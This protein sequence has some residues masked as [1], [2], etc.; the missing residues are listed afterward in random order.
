MPVTGWGEDAETPALPVT[1]MLMARRE[2][3]A[4]RLEI[5]QARSAA[6]DARAAREA[7][8]SAPD[9]D[10]Y[11][12]NFLARGYAPGMISQ[13]SMQLADV[14]AEL[15]GEEDKLEKAA[16]RAE[17][18]RQMHERGQIGG[19][20][21]LARMADTDEGDEGRVRVLQRR[22]ESLRRQIGEATEL[23]AP[24]RAP[25]DPLEA[26]SRNAHAIFREL[27]RAK[28]AEAQA[29]RLASPPFSSVSRAGLSAADAAECTGADCPVCAEGRRMDAAR[30]SE[31]DTDP[32]APGEGY[33][34]V[35]R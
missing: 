18:T 16:R 31:G 1:S 10:Q 25:E 3:Q 12:A 26:P 14:M 13:L 30:N 33:A 19:F 35:Y 6:D 22:A 2:H 11:A 34:E 27:T 28:M 17:R 29:G 15:A 24:Q 4:S 8:A 21:I 7:A 23:M 20:D 5:A 32:Y 9:P